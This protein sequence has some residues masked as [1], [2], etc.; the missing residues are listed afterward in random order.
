ME[1]ALDYQLPGILGEHSTKVQGSELCTWRSVGANWPI[2]LCPGELD[3]I[4]T[5]NA[6][7]M[8]CAKNMEQFRI[9]GTF[10]LSTR[11]QLFLNAKEFYTTV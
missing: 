6:D 11:L 2:I 1:F 7:P 9:I 3:L 10:G 8:I 4:S 5:L